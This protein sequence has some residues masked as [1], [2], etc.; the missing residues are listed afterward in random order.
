MV[1]RR[2]RVGTPLRG[3]ARPSSLEATPHCGSAR[4]PAASRPP[5]KAWRAAAPTTATRHPQRP[6]PHQSPRCT[7]QRPGRSRAA[8][9]QAPRSDGKS[10]CASRGPSAVATSA[11]PCK[12]R[13]EG[14]PV[15]RA[16]MRWRTRA[17]RGILRVSCSV[18]SNLVILPIRRR[19]CAAHT[20]PMCRPL[21]AHVPLLCGRSTR[22]FYQMCPT[23]AE[24]SATLSEASLSLTNFG[25][26]EP[27][28]DR[29]WPT[30]AG[31]RP[32]LLDHGTKRP[33]LFDSGQIQATYGQPRAKA[34]R[35]WPPLAS[36][37]RAKV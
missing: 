17:L 23:S 14:A 33:I 21:A 12:E 2:E 20:S 19:L 4:R 16:W 29:C 36:A 37:D 13:W 8:E 1:G 6:R 3:R 28:F 31:Q 22:A 10:C 24:V 25:R 30:C 27:S 5:R 11:A 34:G 7:A 15:G 26:A 9:V 18:R 35:C 32:S